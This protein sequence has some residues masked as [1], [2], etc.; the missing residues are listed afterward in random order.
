MQS[1][2][3]QSDKLL[4]PAPESIS[5]K[6]GSSCISYADLGCN[7]DSS[8]HAPK[9]QNTLVRFFAFT[10]ILKRCPSLDITFY[11]TQK[12]PI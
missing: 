4:P 11:N 1:K 5:K 10:P 9:N 2:L 6:T 12:K 3:L 8:V 7:E